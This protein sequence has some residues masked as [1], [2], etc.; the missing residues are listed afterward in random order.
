MNAEGQKTPPIQ[1]ICARIL[2]EVGKVA[3]FNSRWDSDPDAIGISH[4]SEEDRVAYVCTYPDGYF[5]SLELPPGP[6]SDR[7]YK[8]GGDYRGLD[9]DQVIDLVRRHL[10]VRE[11]QSSSRA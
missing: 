8:S 10:V 4:Y 2:D 3:K 5:V 11:T 7:P 6:G 9:A 1:Q